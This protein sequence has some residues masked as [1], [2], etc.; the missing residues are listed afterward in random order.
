M[1]S[2]S[3]LGFFTVT[4]REGF[5]TWL[6]FSD[7]NKQIL[8]T[9]GNG[10]IGS[11][12]VPYLE[13]SGYLCT[14]V[15]TGFFK[16]CCLFPEIVSNRKILSQDVRD[17]DLST[18]SQYFAVVHLAGISNDTVGN[19]NPAQVYDPTR[20]YAKEIAQRCKEHGVRFIFASS[21]SIY[22]QATSPIVNEDSLPNPQTPYS[23]NKLQIEQD[24]LEM[25]DNSFHPIMLR[26][27]TVYGLSPR[28]RLDLVINMLTAM[29]VSHGKIVLNSDGKALRPH[30]HILDAS[31]S[32]RCALELAELSAPIV[33]NVGRDEDNLSILGLAQRISELSGDCPIEF[34]NRLSKDQND[35][36][37]LVSDRKIKEGSDT[38]S[39]RVSFEKLATVLPT[40]NAAWNLNKGILEIRGKLLENAFSRADFENRKFYR[41]QTIEDLFETNQ[42]DS[43]LRWKEK[44]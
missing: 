4:E 25:S 16:D 29:S 9:G 10:Y 18:I 2:K 40:F 44:K 8:I 23:L 36:S 34:L 20:F 7:M 1:S 42:I 19:L 17:F 12:L 26:F 22:G 21:C 43:D 28:F 33:V 38:R 6:F 35:F 39:Y 5:I 3:L 27:A 41:L 24:L 31:Q 11:V 13:Q 15:D 30:L 32:V 37:S 14:V